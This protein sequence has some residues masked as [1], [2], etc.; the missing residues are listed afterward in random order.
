MRLFWE[1]RTR[2]HTGNLWLQAQLRGKLLM[3]QQLTDTGI[4]KKQDEQ[5]VCNWQKQF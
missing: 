2:S 5:K 3:A 4:R 1:G